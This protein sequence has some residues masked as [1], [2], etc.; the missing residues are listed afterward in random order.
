MAPSNI[1]FSE[2]IG[3]LPLKKYQK[4]ITHTESVGFAPL[5]R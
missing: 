5:P 3:F 1:K 4:L 2:L